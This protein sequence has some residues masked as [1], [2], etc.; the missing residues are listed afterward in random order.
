MGDWAE[1]EAEEF[2]SLLRLTL[3]DHS[4]N[5]NIFFISLLLT[6]REKLAF[7]HETHKRFFIIGFYLTKSQE[8]NLLRS[9]S[10]TK[11][12]TCSIPVWF[13]RKKYFHNISC[14]KRTIFCFAWGCDANNCFYFNR[15]IRE[16]FFPIVGLQFSDRFF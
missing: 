4:I 5:I 10:G 1:K 11:L 14:V 15:L 8:K 9:A 16:F 12:I 13:R 7:L 3:F 6:P 2:Y